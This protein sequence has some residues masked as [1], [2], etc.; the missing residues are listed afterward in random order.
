MHGALAKSAA[1]TERYPHAILGDRYEA[2][3]LLVETADGRILGAAAPEQSVFEDL[4][5]RL[6]D[7]DQDGSPEVWVIRTDA[8]HG[9]G[10]E[11]YTIQAGKL[12]R[13]YGTPPI[14]MGFRWLNPIGVA[15]FVGD[16][17]RQLA[18]VITPHIGGILTLYR[19]EGDRLEPIL[20][21][22]G[23]S[24]HAV[25]STQL[26][27]SWI[28]DID[29]DGLADILLPEQNR[30]TLAAVSLAGGAISRLAETERFGP[31]RTG[32]AVLTLPDGSRAAVF[33]DDGPGLRW[34]RLP[35]PP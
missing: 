23:Y 29:G 18:L 8:Q 15:D 5:P 32:L 35:P 4:E 28:G 6:W 10:L 22:G 12:S 16:G 19:L 17:T 21:A 13:R 33:A 1:P 31:L 14:G 3:T 20:A 11:A 27:L 25:G 7:L 34:L 30:Q 9:A 2:A 26:G 24:N